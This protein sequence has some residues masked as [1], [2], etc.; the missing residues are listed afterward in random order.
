MRKSKYT[1][2]QIAAILQEAEAGLAV[3]EE[4]ASTASA[5]PRSTSGGPNTA[6]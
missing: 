1:E 2:S 3:S 5:R 4:H 6:A